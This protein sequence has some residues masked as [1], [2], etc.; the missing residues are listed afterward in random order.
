MGRKEPSI[1][2]VGCGPGSPE[3]LTPAAMKAVSRAEVLVGARRLLDLFLS[4]QAER[5]EVG[6]GTGEIL[7]RIEAR[8]CHR[9]IAVLVTGDPGLFSLAKLVL[10]R[11][12]RDNCRV[13]PGISSVHAAFASVGVD[14]AD[15]RV[16]SAHKENPCCDASVW[17]SDKIAVLGGR[18][19]FPRWIA[20]Q[21][22]GCNS[23]DRLIFVCENLTLEDERIREVNLAD[24]ATLEVASRG[25]I[26]VIKRSCLP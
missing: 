22:A 18:P 19:G 26:L 5:I 17:E 23:G 20:E 24:L 14:W 15:A 8:R 6:A 2:I 3:Y 10:E 13:I 7:D 9:R 21:L 16:I 4:S 1:S 25:V 11:F 12:G